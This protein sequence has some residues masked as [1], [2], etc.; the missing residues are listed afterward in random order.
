MKYNIN[1]IPNKNIVRY[2]RYE[3]YDKRFDFINSAI[4]R[5]YYK[6]IIGRKSHKNKDTNCKQQTDVKSLHC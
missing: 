3:T 5:L 1:A 4:F 2:S 6:V